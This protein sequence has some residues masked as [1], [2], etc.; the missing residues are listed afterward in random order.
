MEFDGSCP[1]GIPNG[2]GEKRW[3]LN[4]QIN[5]IIRANFLNGDTI[6]VVKMIDY[7]KKYVY[8]GEMR[9]G[10]FDG[11]GKIVYENGREWTGDWRG[12]KQV[13]NNNTPIYIPVPVP[14][15][16]SNP[17]LDFANQLQRTEANAM[18]RMQQQHEES[19]RDGQMQD[20]C[21]QVRRTNP[22]CNR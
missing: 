7:T 12:G 13:A 9:G 21:N 3:Y 16:E 2:P 19:V 17:L 15:S 8:E 11:T 18:R 14:Q 10:F 4:G 6:G 1:N 20:L 22:L 5:Q